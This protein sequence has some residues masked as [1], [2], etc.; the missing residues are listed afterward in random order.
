MKFVE[1]YKIKNDG[2]QKVSAVCELK[3]NKVVC[4]GE[5]SF[6]ASL[7][8]DGIQDYSNGNGTKL[9]PKDGIRFLENLKFTFKSGYLNASDI[10]SKVGG[11]KKSFKK[12]K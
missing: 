4:R 2:S 1:I 5:K 6:V 10:K 9:F 12:N 3:N 11:N 8:A 7:V